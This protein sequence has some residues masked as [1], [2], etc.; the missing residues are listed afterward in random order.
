[1]TLRLNLLIALAMLVSGST[2]ALASYVTGRD[3]DTRNDNGATQR[4]FGNNYFDFSYDSRATHTFDHNAGEDVVKFA[5]AH[6]APSGFGSNF[7]HGSSDRDGFDYDNHA[8]GFD[9]EHGREWDHAFDREHWTDRGH[10]FDRDHDFGRDHDFDHDHDHGYGRD[11]D[12]D[13][14]HGIGGGG[15][16]TAGV[17]EVSTWIMMILGFAGLGFVTWRRNA[18]SVSAVA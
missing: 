3:Y 13:G 16:I 9:R 5:L 8:T 1:M 14:G 4:A 2:G 17:P 10:E 11:H 18:K 15:G 7:N 6:S 12:D